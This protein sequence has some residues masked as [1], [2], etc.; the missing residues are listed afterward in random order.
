MSAVAIDIDPN[1]LCSPTPES[2]R[3]F[4]PRLMLHPDDITSIIDIEEVMTRIQGMDTMEIDAILLCCGLGGSIID[5]AP[6][7][8]EELRKSYLEPIFALAVLPCL[9]EGKRVSAKAADD[10]ELLREIT[11]PSSSSITR[12]GR[13]N[14][15]PQRPGRKRSASWVRY[16]GTRSLGR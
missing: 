8:I 15:P 4:F 10:L 11:M 13:R 5:I 2:A 6:P 9:D 7:V 12:P 1:S 16:A 14:Q 3:I